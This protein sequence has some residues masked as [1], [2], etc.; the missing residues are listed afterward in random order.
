M[1]I[2]RSRDSA[3]ICSFVICCTRLFFC[4]IKGGLQYSVS[5][6]GKFTLLRYLSES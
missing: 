5:A 2:V 1:R 6:L 4:L 3:T